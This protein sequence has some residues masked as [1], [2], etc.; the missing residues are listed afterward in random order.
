MLM[1]FEVSN[2][3]EKC[4][5]KKERRK[6]VKNNYQQ[7]MLNAQSQT[8]C[9]SEHQNQNRKNKKNKTKLCEL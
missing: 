9:M 1:F 4:I 8:L 3:L 2:I 7:K 6:W 5:E